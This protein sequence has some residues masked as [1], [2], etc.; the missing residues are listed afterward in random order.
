MDYIQTIVIQN[1]GAPSSNGIYSRDSG[2][3]T[4]FYSGNGSH[5]ENT[6]DGWYLIDA[7]RQEQTYLFDENFETV[8]A[9]GDVI[10][11]VPTF[12]LFYSEEIQGQLRS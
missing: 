3:N 9:V 12:E 4:W 11:P 6:V 1:A 5:I 7:V 10:L 8:T 2:G